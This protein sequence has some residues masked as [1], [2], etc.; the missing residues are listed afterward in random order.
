MILKTSPVMIKMIKVIKMRLS[1]VLGDNAIQDLIH[2][3][4]RKTKSHKGMLTSSKS[5][6]CGSHAQFIFSQMK[7]SPEGRKMAS[8]ADDY[9][10]TLLSDSSHSTDSKWDP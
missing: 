1:Y 10:C 9:Y 3:T 4:D 8:D 6:G 2:Y 5:P 7:L